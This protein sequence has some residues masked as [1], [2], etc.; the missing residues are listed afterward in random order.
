MPFLRLF[1]RIRTLL[2]ELRKFRKLLKN[3]SNERFFAFIK[4]KIINKACTDEF[5]L[6]KQVPK[7]DKSSKTWKPSSAIHNYNE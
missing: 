2:R 4:R 5:Y 3:S 6:V 1:T 7:K